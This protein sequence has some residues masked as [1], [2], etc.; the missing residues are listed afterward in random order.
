MIKRILTLAILI[1]LQKDLQAQIP[2]AMNY[3]AVARNANGSLL[4]FT[5]I[6]LRFSILDGGPSGTAQYVET[7]TQQTNQFGLFTV[8]IGQGTVQSGNFAMVS[9]FAGN[10]FLKVEMD[11]AGG[12]NYTLTSTTEL[13]SVP[14]SLVAERLSTPPQLNLDDLIDVYAP[15]PSI[16][17][18]VL[19][20]NGVTWAADSDFN[21]T[22]QAGKGLTLSGDT[23]SLMPL[24]QVF[25]AGSGISLAGDTISAFS[26]VVSYVAGDGLVISGDT[27]TNTGDINAGDDITNITTAGGDLRGAYP[28]PEVSGLLGRPIFDTIPG[29]GEVLAYDV[30]SGFWKPAEITTDAFS[31]PYVA[32]VDTGADAFSVQNTGSGNAAYFSADTGFALVTGNGNVGIGMLNPASKLD[33]NGD[34]NSSGK[35]LR[36][37][38]GS[39]NL[40]PIAYGTIDGSGNIFTD[41]STGNFTVAKVGLGTYDISI[42]GELFDITKFSVAITLADGLPGATAYS[43]VNNTLEIIAFDFWTGMSTDRIISFQVYKK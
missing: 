38:T 2:Q 42:S 22:Y 17:G 9:W 30:G 12:T 19:K 25:V 31:L 40:V 7:Q 4:Q 24:D 27:I 20:Y 43:A 21:S 15:A 3:Q 28:A 37:S 10:K 33:V 39:S 1:F 26:A 34:I 23:F 16:T 8:N 13:L 35:V 29:Q 32:A 18:Q 41:A 36:T 5:N 14:F 6:G 11:A